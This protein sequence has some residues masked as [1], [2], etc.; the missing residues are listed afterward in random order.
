MVIEPGRFVRLDG[1]R[2]RFRVRQVIVN[3]RT[4]EP[5]AVIDEVDGTGYATLLVPLSR[6][7]VE[8]PGDADA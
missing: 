4:Q 3:P 2:K 7:P 5:N 6:L 8:V 1:S